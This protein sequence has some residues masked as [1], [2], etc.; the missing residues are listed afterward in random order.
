[1]KLSVGK[2]SRQETTRFIYKQRFFSTQPERCL[3]FSLIELD[4]LL[5]CCLIHVTITVLRHFIFTT[6]VSISR[7]RSIYAISM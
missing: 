6:F 5:R 2:L 3:T 4:M 1:M 7:S